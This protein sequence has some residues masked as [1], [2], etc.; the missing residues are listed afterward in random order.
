[1]N[2]YTLPITVVPEMSGVWFD[3][4]HGQTY[5]DTR[6]L[7]LATEYGFQFDFELPYEGARFGET[8]NLTSVVWSELTQSEKEGVAQLYELT[9]EAIQYLNDH[10]VP[11]GYAFQWFEG[12]FRLDAFF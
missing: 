6:V 8:R 3:G 10:I 4:A 12:D 11:E 9:N 5:N 1:M 2:K 7:N